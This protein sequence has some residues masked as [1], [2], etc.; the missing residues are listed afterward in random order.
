MV[1]EP[2]DVSEEWQQFYVSTK[3][4]QDYA[5][6]EAGYTIQVADAKQTLRVGPIFVMNLGQNIGDLNLPRP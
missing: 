5:P 3:A 6:S 4:Q 1:M 2:A